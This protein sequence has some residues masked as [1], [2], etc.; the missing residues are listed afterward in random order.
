[1]VDGKLVGGKVVY[2]N[3]DGT[4]SYTNK[5]TETVKVYAPANSRVKVFYDAELKDYY[6]AET[7]ISGVQLDV[8][9]TKY[10]NMWARLLV[11]ARLREGHRVRRRA[12]RR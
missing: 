3:D 7:D 11:P 5:P 10:F 9:V 8:G 2:V 12:R 4:L 6:V 1:M